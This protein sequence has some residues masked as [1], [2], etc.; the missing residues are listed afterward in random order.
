METKRPYTYILRRGFRNSWAV[1]LASVLAFG[2]VSIGGPRAGASQFNA[3]V[4]MTPLT[5]YGRLGSSFTPGTPV[6]LSGASGV[7]VATPTV[8]GLVMLET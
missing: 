6:E 2:T 1:G 5:P 4:T 8:R 7:T 3:I